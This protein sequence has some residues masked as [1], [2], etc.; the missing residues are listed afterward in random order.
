MIV[1]FQSGMLAGCEIGVQQ[2]EES[3]TGYVHVDPSDPAKNRRFK[4]IT[5]FTDGFPMPGGNFSPVVGDKY[6]VFGMKMPD[7]YVRDDAT[8]SGASWDLF[9]EAIRYKYENEDYRFTFKGLWKWK[10]IWNR[11]WIWK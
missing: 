5:E 3:V 4:L 2:D 8:K 1:V 9:R 7:A 10:W 6:A 11:K